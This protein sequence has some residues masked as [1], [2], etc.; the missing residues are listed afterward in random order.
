MS[1]TAET[2]PIWPI[3]PDWTAPVRESIAFG[4]LVDQA[5]QTG[6]TYHRAIADTARRRLAFEVLSAGRERRA[7]D[8]LLAGHSGVW[9]LPIWPDVQ[10]VRAP[11]VGGTDVVGCDTAGFDFRVGGRALIWRAVNEFEVVTIAEIGADYLALDQGVNGSW[12]RGDHLYPLRLAYVDQGAEEISLSDN[13]GRRSLAF[14]I[15]EPSDWPVL[16]GLPAY[17]GHAVLDHRPDESEDP[18]NGQGRLIDIADNGTGPLLEFDLAGLSF[19][20][21]QTHWSL[22]GRPEHTWFR[23]LLYLLRG[24]STPVWLPSWAPDLLLAAPLA[25][26][27]VSLVVG[28]AA[29]TLAGRQKPNRRDLCIELNDGTRYFRRV[30]DAAEAGEQEVLTLDSALGESIAPEHVRAVSIMAL[31]TLASDEIDIEHKTDADGV[32][33]STLGWKAVLPD[34]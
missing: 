16:D 23:S 33:T 2:T 20:T 26:D 13:V 5:P 14:T 10:A 34:V 1:F 24:R 19:N 11:L 15:A 22:F 4:T 29:Y 28:W 25:S 12:R 7:A 18:R 31:S 32:A 30:L 6:A 8:M 9:Q 3:T 27:S 17:R 21:R